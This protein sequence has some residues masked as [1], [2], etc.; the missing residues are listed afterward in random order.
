MYCHILSN[1]ARQSDESPDQNES[2]GTICQSSIVRFRTLLIIRLVIISIHASLIVH[3]HLR[4]PLVISF[5]I[6]SIH[7]SLIV[8][9]HVRTPFIV[10]LGV[11]RRQ[12]PLVVRIC[13][14]RLSTSLTRI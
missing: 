8:R 3:V 6:I 10:C 11:I 1:Y 4:T 14:A 9:L 13:R 7:A 5:I 2:P 12:I